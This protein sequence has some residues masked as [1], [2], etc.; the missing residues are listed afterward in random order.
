MNE[1]T[2]AEIIFWIILN[3]AMWGYLFFKVWRDTK[4]EQERMFKK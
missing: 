2:N 3:I 1:P 4:R